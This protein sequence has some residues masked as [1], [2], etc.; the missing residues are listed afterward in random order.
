MGKVMGGE[1]WEWGRLR[2]ESGGKF[3]KW[4]EEPEGNLAHASLDAGDRH[5][6]RGPQEPARCG[7]E[8]EGEENHKYR[9]P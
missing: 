1:R 6:L 5:P 7:L 8:H 4:E 9:K 3:W 2:R